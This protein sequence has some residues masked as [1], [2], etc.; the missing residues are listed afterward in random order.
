VNLFLNEKQLLE[1]LSNEE[2]MLLDYFQ[3]VML[4]KE[5]G[6]VV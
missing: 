1:F 3:E 4:K 5:I 6:V 2:Q